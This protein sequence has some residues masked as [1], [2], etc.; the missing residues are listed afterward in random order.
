MRYYWA[1]QHLQIYKNKET[2]YA[3]WNDNNFLL[4][5]KIITTY[6]EGLKQA[7]TKCE[8]PKQQ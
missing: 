6:K 7:Y 3:K 4:I 1:E 5:R 8:L 2:E